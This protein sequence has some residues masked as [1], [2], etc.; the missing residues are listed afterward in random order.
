[1]GTRAKTGT[2]AICGQYG[3]LTFEHIPPRSCYNNRS[4]EILRG[5]KTMDLSG[6]KQHRGQ[7]QQRGAGDYHSCRRCNNATGRMY[8]PETIRWVQRGAE[9]LNQIGDRDGQDRQ[10]YPRF[11]NVVFF[12]VK[13]LLFLKQVVYMFLCINGPGFSAAHP[14]LRAFVLNRESQ[15]LPDVH[16]FHVALTWGPG[17]RSV[18]GTAVAD[19]SSGGTTYLSDI[20]F[21]PFSYVM[22]LGQHYR[23]LAPCEITDFKRFDATEMR[24]V[25]LPL[26]VGFTHLVLP[27]D[28]RSRAELDR[29][30]DASRQ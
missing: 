23:A 14:D 22:W 20:S 8:V 18:A 15:D 3:D 7:I 11:V 12:G 29:Q 6:D 5:M 13:P 16:H 28:Y 4:V 17:A 9:V 2:C 26:Q 10:P 27:S 25:R 30:A 21:P 1:M 24:D 19:I